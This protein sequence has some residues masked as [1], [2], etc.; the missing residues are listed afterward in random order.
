MFTRTFYESAFRHGKTICEAFKAAVQSLKL[1]D[2]YAFRQDWPAYILLSKC[3]QQCAQNMLFEHSHVQNND[4]QQLI[5]IE[6]PLHEIYA[7]D[8]ELD[9]VR[10]LVNSSS[11]VHITAG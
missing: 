11:V 9:T 5:Q 6:R 8:R 3:P 2:D 10:R 4:T 7:R 1:H